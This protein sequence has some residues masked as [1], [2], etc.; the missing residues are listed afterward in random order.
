VELREWVMNNPRGWD[1]GGNHLRSLAFPVVKRHEQVAGN[2]SRTQIIVRR[3]ASSVYSGVVCHKRQ[4]KGICNGG[5]LEGERLM[6]D[7]FN[8]V[9]F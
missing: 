1:Y 6:K 2:V 8:N 7:S 5:L 3:V 9:G 4:C